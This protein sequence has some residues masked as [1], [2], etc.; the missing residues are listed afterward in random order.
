MTTVFI[1]MDGVVADF[2]G[3]AERTLGI[4]SKPGIRFDQEDW[5][6]LRD[7][8]NRIYSILPVLPNAYSLVSIKTIT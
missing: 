7:H 2:D 1:D 4:K 6:R 5:Y 8:S 3:Y